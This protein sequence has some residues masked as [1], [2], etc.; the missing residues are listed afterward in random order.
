MV[1]MKKR[2]DE[3]IPTT[4]DMIDRDAQTNVVG[5]RVGPPSFN[6]ETERF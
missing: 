3:M 5:K 2:V 4:N 1:N 6:S